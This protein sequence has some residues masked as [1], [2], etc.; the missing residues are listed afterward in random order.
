[1]RRL[2]GATSVVFAVILGLT[3]LIESAGAPTVGAAVGY[4][5]IPSSPSRSGG[6]IGLRTP[7]TLP[8]SAVPTTR[9]AV[10][11]LAGK[12]LQSL[13]TCPQ[14]IVLLALTPGSEALARRI[15]ARYGPAVKISVGL[16]D[17]DGK[18]GRSPRCGPLPPTTAVPPGLA[19]SL[20]LTSRTVRSGSN[21]AGSVVVRNKGTGSFEMDTGQPMQAVVVRTGTRRVVGVYSG[22]IAGTGY[23][24][25]IEPGHS[26]RVN[27]FGGTARCDGGYGSALPAGRYQVVTL[28]MDESGKAPRFATPPVSLTVTQP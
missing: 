27:V 28:V 21:F 10:E 22:G 5:Q 11:E 17:W 23:G 2:K 15:Q 7:S 3:L 1:M 24:P 6:C 18:P 13:G 14:G 26:Y 8:T 19:V 12:H 20:R 9:A 16:T 4:P 25:R